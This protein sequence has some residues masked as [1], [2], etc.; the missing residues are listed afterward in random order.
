VGPNVFLRGSTNLGVPVNAVD[1][2]GQV[3][4]ILLVLALIAWAARLL[5]RVQTPS[6]ADAGPAEQAAPALAAERE[7]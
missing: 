3:V 4:E 7:G 1:I 5:P 2:A 6:A